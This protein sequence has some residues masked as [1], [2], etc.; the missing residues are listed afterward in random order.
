MDLMNLAFGV[1]GLLVFA[2]VL[3]GLYSARAGLS[4]LLV[5]L[6]MGMLAGEDGPGGI[7]FNDVK[8]SLWVGSAALGVILLDGGLRTRLSTFRT[9]L[10]PAA[11]L[12]TVGVLV[13]AALTGLAASLAFGLPPLLGL[14]AGAIVG[15]TDAAA[16]FA[17]LKSS[18]L[19]VS[20]RLSST[21]E[22]ESGLNDPMAVFLVLTLSAALLQ[23]AAATPWAMLWMF[24]QQAVLGTLIGVLAGMGVGELLKRLPLGGT[25]EGL[26]ALLLLAAGIGVFGGAGWVGGSGFLAVYL[27]GLVVAHRASEVVER[28]LAGMDGFAWLAQALM[29]LLLGLL[30]TPS[31]LLENWLPTLA[32][33]LAL[34]FVARP[35]AV[36]LC[37]KPLRFSWQEIG[38]ISWVG[39]RGAVPVVLALI[40]LM[41]AVPQARVLFDVAFVVVLASL[42]L[43]GSTM[44][45]AARLFNV[46]LPDAQDEPAVREVFGDF[47]LDP[48]VP[49][50]DICG[51]YGLPDPG[52]DGDVAEWMARELRRPPVAGDGIDWGHAHFAVRG[53]DGRRVAQVG[54]LLY[55]TKGDEDGA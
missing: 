27:F 35:L 12:A 34:M 23:P 54:L 44:V 17:L 3:A 38:F 7:A 33:A 40:P 43:Q 39:L 1:T 24:G 47:A 18:G 5:F 30:V 42:V 13:T 10:K 21:L 26:T 2:S 46:N 16:V 37:L 14:L 53:M 11:W 28:A 6:V 32:V 52:F 36:A 55:H 31:R 29:F 4:F 49:V 15:S 9:G 48:G 51:F 22:I 25:A 45:W 8:L 19:R 20:E 41:L 50:R